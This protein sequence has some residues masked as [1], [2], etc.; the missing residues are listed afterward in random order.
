LAHRQ[1]IIDAAEIGDF[2]G[3][4]ETPA[5]RVF[6]GIT[7]LMNSGDGRAIYAEALRRIPPLI[8]GTDPDA[9]QIDESL[10]PLR[11]GVELVE[12]GH[13][14][15]SLIG[16]R[17][18]HYV[19]PS[20]V[21]GGD[22][23]RASYSPEFNEAISENAILLPQVRARCDAERACL[24]S[25]ERKTGWFHDLWLPGYLWAD[26]EGLWRVPSAP[27]GQVRREDFAQRRGL[28]LRHGPATH[29]S[30]A[31]DQYVRCLARALRLRGVSWILAAGVVQE[32]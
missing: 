16:A 23:E 21:A 12:Q 8:D 9:P 2:W 22:D 14:S 15:R 17:L 25:V 28:L 7:R 11:R 27:G 4:G 31:L 5:Q 6:Q 19:V 10:G 26:T 1:T 29:R 18:A 3:W 30:C 20:A 32:K 13:I 24:V